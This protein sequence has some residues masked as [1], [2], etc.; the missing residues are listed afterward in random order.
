MEQKKICSFNEADYK[1]DH[2]TLYEYI[3]THQ[4]EFILQWP[5]EN[6]STMFYSDKQKVTLFI[7]LY[8]LFIQKN[9]GFMMTN[10]KWQIIY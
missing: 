2:C 5:V 4:I 8:N 10:L 9:K 3:Y 7:S 1:V 6:N